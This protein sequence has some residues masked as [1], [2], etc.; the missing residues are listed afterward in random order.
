MGITILGI[1]G[2]GLLVVQQLPAGAAKPGDQACRGISGD[3]SGT[4]GLLPQPP[5]DSA[6]NWIL[7]QKNTSRSHGK[8]PDTCTSSAPVPGKNRPFPL[9]SLLQEKMRQSGMDSVRSRAIILSGKGKIF[10]RLPRLIQSRDPTPAVAPSRSRSSLIATGDAGRKT[11]GRK[12]TERS[13]GSSRLTYSHT[14]LPLPADTMAVTGNPLC[15]K[16]G[17][18]VGRNL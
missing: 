11:S 9:I 6:G 17:N 8:T 18:R 16:T 7:F 3:R 2:S 5:I 15:R 12:T 4:A 14:A 13:P 1:T 10:R